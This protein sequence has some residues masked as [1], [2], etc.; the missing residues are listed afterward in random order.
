MEWTLSQ[1]RFVGYIHVLI[2]FQQMQL[3]QFNSDQIGSANVETV[4]KMLFKR[5]EIRYDLA[6]Q[7]QNLGKSKRN[8][9][10]L[11][12]LI[13]HSMLLFHGFPSHGFNIHKNFD[14]N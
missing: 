1:S 10:I 3:F 2:N 13:V 11:F 12:C 9:R 5:L 14:I 6:T 7:L 4:M 8:K